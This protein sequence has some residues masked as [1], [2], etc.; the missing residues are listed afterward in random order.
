MFRL[1]KFNRKVLF[2]IFCLLNIIYALLV[3]SKSISRVQSLL[4]NLNLDSAVRL[5]FKMWANDFLFANYD[6][7]SDKKFTEEFE[8]IKK[9]KIE[10][11][12]GNK[13][14]YL[15]QQNPEGL[16]LSIDIPNYFYDNSKE[17]PIIQQFDARMTIGMYLK[18]IK[19]NPDRKVPFHWS[20]WIDF[21]PLNEELFTDKKSDCQSFDINEGEKHISKYCSNENNGPLNFLISSQ[22]GRQTQEHLR[23]LNKAYLLTTAKSPVRLVFMTANQGSFEV[24]VADPHTNNLENSLPRNKIIDSLIEGGKIDTT[25]NVLNVFNELVDFSNRKDELD[26]TEYE[27]HISQDSFNVNNTE[28]ILELEN[29]ADLTLS[30][31]AYLDSLKF[32]VSNNSPPKYFYES[33][34]STRYKKTG[35]HYD[36]RFFNHLIEMEDQSMHLHRLIKNYLNFSRQHKFITWIAHGSLL[37]WYWNGVAFPWDSDID[38]Q[39]PIGELHRLSRHYNQSLVIENTGTKDKEFDGFGRYFIDIGSTIT[40][41]TKENGMNNIDARFI[42]IDTGLYIDITALALT[43]IGAPSRYDHIIE[44]DEKKKKAVLQSKDKDG[45]INN[46]VRNS[47][48]QVYNCR[49][50]HFS[51]LEELSP[52][53]YTLVENQPTY[54]PSN[55]MLSLNN[56][57]SLKGLSEKNFLDYIYLKNFRI[58]VTTQLVLDYLNDPQIFYYDHD[59][60]LNNPNSEIEVKRDTEANKEKNEKPNLFKRLVGIWEKQAINKLTIDDHINLL[61][62]DFIFLEFYNTRE[63]TKFHEL[64]IR[65][66]IEKGIFKLELDKDNPIHATMGK[67]MRPDNFLSK[68]YTLV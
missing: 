36:W 50:H 58:W 19:E 11:D 55:F 32:S 25:V 20:D 6:L 28:I 14:W 42:D 34:L 62:N 17:R 22:P 1:Q 67:P 40:H 23:T 21:S 15:K 39:M 63:C 41:R 30:E 24:E 9:S 31:S 64:E 26:G 7:D 52:L 59:S 38:V 51:S 13:H 27:M 37:A 66:I 47:E 60:L 2:Q 49:N 56:E 3:I 4:S 65:N 12:I 68:L 45:S 29:K 8:K 16:P 61:H 5:N 57:Y 53:I 33:L 54:V 43:N 46:I 10:N 44:S 35:T 18:Y 48:L